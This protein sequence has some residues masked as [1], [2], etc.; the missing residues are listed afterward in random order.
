MRLSSRIAIAAAAIGALVLLWDSLDTTVELGLASAATLLIVVIA[1]PTPWSWLRPPQIVLYTVLIGAIGA[2]LTLLAAH[3]DPAA[4]GL[5]TPLATTPT[6][7]PPSSPARR[8]SSP[9]PNTNTAAT[10]AMFPSC[11]AG[12]AS[13]PDGDDWG[14]ENNRTCVVPGGKVATTYAYCQDASADDDDGWGW[15]SNQSCIVH[16]GKAD[17]ARP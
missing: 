12:K 4:L 15:E 16:N 14:W 13:D 3:L 5:P 17:P 1:A 8:P 9:P 7:Q 6:T 10:K 2:S 11:T